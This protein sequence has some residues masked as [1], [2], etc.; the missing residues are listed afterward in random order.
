MENIFTLSN[1]VNFSPINQTKNERKYKMRFSP[2]IFG[3]IKTLEK[4]IGFSS[5]HRKQQLRTNKHYA[6]SYI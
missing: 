4:I 3:S 5:D 2:P 6:L 1:F